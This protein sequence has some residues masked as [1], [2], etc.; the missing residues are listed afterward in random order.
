M[1]HM[2]N[3]ATLILYS[4]C[5]ATSTA[6]AVDKDYLRELKYRFITFNAIKLPK[7]IDAFTTIEKIKLLE[8]N[9]VHY[10][11]TMVTLRTDIEQFDKK[12]LNTFKTG[13]IN[14]GCSDQETLEY[15]NH[16][17]RIGVIYK[18]TASNTV[19]EFSYSLNDCK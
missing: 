2:I 12:T 3:K 16:G 14:I 5:F 17:L 10:V 13:S 9:G 8:I 1:K 15:M 11:A 4:I 6:H 7:K 19:G 18:N